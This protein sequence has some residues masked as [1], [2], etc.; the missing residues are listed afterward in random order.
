MNRLLEQ[1]YE[2]SLKVG[3][4][5]YFEYVNEENVFLYPIN[6]IC[7]SSKWGEGEYGYERCKYDLGAS[8]N[9]EIMKIEGA[10]VALTTE[11]KNVIEDG[12]YKEWC[13]QMKTKSQ[14]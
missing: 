14:P 4:D 11:Q 9:G 7:F 1:V 13:K 3:D 6:I 12:I 5:F 2:D 10:T 8:I